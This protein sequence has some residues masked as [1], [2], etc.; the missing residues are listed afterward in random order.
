MFLG[1]VAFGK[2]EVTLKRWNADYSQT[3]DAQGSP[4]TESN[5]ASVEKLLEGFSKF[6]R[7][8]LEGAAKLE[9]S[10]AEDRMHHYA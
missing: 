1:V 4:T 6:V 2:P 8:L 9:R 5:H 10:Y 7:V 3:F